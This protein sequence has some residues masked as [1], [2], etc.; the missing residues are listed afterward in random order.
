MKDILAKLGGFSGATA[1]QKIEKTLR[2]ATGPRSGGWQTEIR[3]RAALPDTRLNGTGRGARAADGCAVIGQVG[4]ATGGYAQCV[5][6][7]C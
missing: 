7:S 4:T 2:S 5:S 1:L 6:A 3:D